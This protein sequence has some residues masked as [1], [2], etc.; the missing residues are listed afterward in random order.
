MGDLG[1]SV[2]CHDC[3]KE[4]EC[5]EEMLSYPRYEQVCYH[6]AGKRQRVAKD[7]LE[8]YTDDLEP[9]LPYYD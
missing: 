9:C 3:G 2:K 4:I 7:V 1:Y 8:P 5:G 6:C